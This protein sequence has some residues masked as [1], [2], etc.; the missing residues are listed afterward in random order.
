MIAL[1]AASMFVVSPAARADSGPTI[2]VDG[3]GQTL[4][5][6]DVADLDV[7]VSV[8][9]RS[10]VH[11]RNRANR[12]INALRAA[13]RSLG[14]PAADLQTTQAGLQSEV[15]LV[16]RRPRR[17]RV[18]YNASNAVHVHITRIALLGPVI[19]SASRSG[20]TSVDGPS[21]SLSD[22]SAGKAVATR[23][24]LTDARRRADD[25]A[26]ALGYRVTGVQSVI[27]DP[28]RG[29]GGDVS[30][31]PGVPSAGSAPQRRPATATP[32]SVGRQEVDATARVTY[33][34]APA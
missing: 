30:P 34:M 13:L 14:I 28:T 5:T 21:F 26:S 16:G 23:L 10:A 9:D 3:A 29:S 17:R 20:V 24:A 22:P 19:D 7:S 18:L 25:A 2:T 15:Q 11:A 1:V 12:R 33:T 27:I 32:I 6:P 4:V 8:R 31:A